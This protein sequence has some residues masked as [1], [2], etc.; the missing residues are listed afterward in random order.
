MI[1]EL[2]DGGK[3]SSVIIQ[4]RSVLGQFEFPNLILNQTS[5]ARASTDELNPERQFSGCASNDFLRL[6]GHRPIL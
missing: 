1:F 5:T 3:S 2:C 6:R 4:G